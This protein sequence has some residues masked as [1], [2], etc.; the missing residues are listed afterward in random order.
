MLGLSVSIWVDKFLGVIWV[1]PGIIWG[2]INTNGHMDLKLGGCSHHLEGSFL[3]VLQMYN[4]IVHMRERS[5]QLHSSIFLIFQF[6]VSNDTLKRVRERE[7]FLVWFVCFCFV[8]FCCFVFVLLFCFFFRQWRFGPWPYG[9]VTWLGCQ[10][11]VR[12]W[13]EAATTK[14]VQFTTDFFFWWEQMSLWH[15]Q[16]QC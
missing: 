10:N 2:H 9:M 7:R 15:H 5:A 16:G 1:H 4:I 8:L 13:G 6:R 3:Q 12:F 11:Q 14:S